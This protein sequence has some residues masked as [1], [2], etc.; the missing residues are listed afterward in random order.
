MELRKR[1]TV[2]V[3]SELVYAFDPDHEHVF[4]AAR[5]KGRIIARPMEEVAMPGTRIR[6]RKVYN[7]GYASGMKA[8]YEDGYRKGYNDCMDSL[9]YDSRYDTAL[10]YGDGGLNS[11]HC[12]GHCTTCRYYDDINGTCVDL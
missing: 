10:D 2:L 9:E 8:G 7:N 1:I 3:P 12:T 4:I 5:E 6:G 11:F